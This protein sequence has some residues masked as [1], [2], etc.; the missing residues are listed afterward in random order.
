MFS[1]LVS[2]LTSSIFQSCAFLFEVNSAVFSFSSRF[3]PSVLWHPLLDHQIL[4]S[5]FVL[6]LSALLMQQTIA[7][8]LSTSSRLNLPF[9]LQSSTLPPFHLLSLEVFG[10]S[11][12]KLGFVYFPFFT[13]IIITFNV[14]KVVDHKIW[15]LDIFRLQIQ[16]EISIHRT[17]CRYKKK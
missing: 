12:C 13:S 11:L 1:D 15:T 3:S 2:F 7:I 10:Q 5:P 8:K 4:F 6:R 17:L 14:L 9:N 16:A